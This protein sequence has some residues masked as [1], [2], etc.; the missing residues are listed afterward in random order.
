MSAFL[1][2]ACG[3]IEFELTPTEEGDSTLNTRTAG[4]T[5]SINTSGSGGTFDKESADGSGITTENGGTTG[6]GGTTDSGGTDGFDGAVGGNDA[7]GDVTDDSESADD[8][9]IDGGSSTDLVCSTP[10]ENPNGSAECVDGACVVTCIDDYADCDDPSDGCETDLMTDPQH[11]GSC[12]NE[13][14]TDSQTCIDGEC[15]ITSC[16]AGLAD[17]DGVL[18]NGCETDLNTSLL[19]CGTCGNACIANNGIAQCVGGTCNIAECDSGFDDCDGLLINGCEAD[20]KTSLQNCGYCGNG[21]T[22]NN[23]TAECADGTCNIADCNSGFDD[24]DGS[25][26]NGCEADLN[27]SLQNCGYCNNPCSANNGTAEC[28]DGTCDI[29]DCNSG[30]DDCDGLYINGCEAGL[31]TSLQNCG[32]CG[33]GCTANNGTAECADGTCNIADCNSGFDDCDGL[34]NNGCET[35]LNT[36]LED[37]GYCGNACPDNYGDDGAP[38]CNSGTCGTVCDLNGTFALKVTAAVSWPAATWISAGSGTFYSWTKLQVSQSGN[39]LSVTI[40]ECEWNTPHIKSSFYNEWYKINY[41]T[42]LFDSTYLPS[43]S[44]TAMLSSSSPGATLNLTAVTMLKGTTTSSGTWALGTASSL[45]S[46]DMDGDGKPGVTA[47]YSNSGSDYY[48]PTSALIG[49]N[50]ADFVYM[51]TRLAFSLSG[52]LNGCTGSSGNALVTHVDNRIFGC[53]RSNST[54]DCSSSEGGFLDNNQPN[55]IAD[56]ATYTLVKLA[57]TATCADVRSALP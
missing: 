36:S 56:S 7:A 39:S 2:A 51:A 8:A 49:A 16:P 27:T 44:T 28:A 23:G 25:Y 47:V 33:N 31:N 24:C 40:V 15:K 45:T 4:T 46:S 5:G 35:D 26:N 30:F 19:N 18:N 20:L 54:S 53:N 17:C 14:D 13:C 10:C 21:C 3:R 1:L 42:S 55:Y 43:A 6:S 32:Y 57:D 48:P 29:A 11:C 22:A 41:P 50:R 9:S 52:T 37:C 34:Y 12:D 38:V